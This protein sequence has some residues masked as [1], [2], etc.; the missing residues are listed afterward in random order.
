MNESSVSVS[1]VFV[2]V[3]LVKRAIFPLLDASAVS[4]V[5]FPLALINVLAFELKWSK[6]MSSGDFKLR[7]IIVKSSKVFFLFS[8]E[9]V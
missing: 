2:P 7:L 6:S 8:D 5:S 4:L 1:Y 9:L 3:S